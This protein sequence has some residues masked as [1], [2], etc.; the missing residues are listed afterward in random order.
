MRRDKRQHR[1]D[2]AYTSLRVSTSTARNIPIL[3]RIPYGKTPKG[4]FSESDKKLWLV[5]EREFQKWKRTPESERWRKRQFLAQGGTCYYCDEPLN[6]TH[7]NIDHVVPKSKRGSNHPDNL[8]LTCWRCNKDKNNKLLT[9][10]SKEEL[11]AKNKAK[12]GTY[13]RLKERYPSETDVAM[14]LYERFR[15]E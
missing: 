13:S 2:R 4:A 14:D 10:K 7:N 3:E 12:R 1:K 6:G 15:E 8:V 9:A 5:T 11:R